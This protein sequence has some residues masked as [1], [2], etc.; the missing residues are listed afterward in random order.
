MN[1]KQQQKQTAKNNTHE[2]KLQG[3]RNTKTN[4]H[5]DDTRTQIAMKKTHENLAQ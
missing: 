4:S 1:K 5:E 2:N 3:I